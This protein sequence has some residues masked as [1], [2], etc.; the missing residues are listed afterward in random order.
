[1]NFSTADRGFKMVSHV[2]PVSGEIQQGNGNITS[3]NLTS[4]QD[5]PHS[6]KIKQEPFQLSPTSSL[7][8]LHQVSNFVSDMSS[9]CM[10]APSKDIHDVSVTNFCRS[11]LSSHHIINSHHH[12]L[13]SP[14]SA[15]SMHTLSSL[16]HPSHNNK[17]NNNSNNNNTNNTNNNNSSNNNSNHRNHH[18]HHHHHQHHSPHVEGKNSSPPIGL[19][20]STNNNNS[21]S[22]SSAPTTNSE[23]STTVSESDSIEPLSTNEKP[24]YSYVALIAMAIN[25]SSQKRA[26]LNEIYGYIT[27]NF[28]YYE[29]N[30]KGWQNSIRHNLSLNECFV[31]VPREGGGE[32]KGNFWT[33][34]PQYHD[35]FEN[36][37]FKRRKRMKR[38]YRSASYHKS[39]FG[40]SFASSHVHLNATRNLFAHSPP[41]Y[42]STGYPRYDTSTWSLQ[43]PQ[44][45]Y[46]HCQGIQSQLQPM[47]HQSMQIPTMNG[48]GQFNS[49]AFQG[50]YIDVS[51]GSSG[52]PGAMAG[53]T[54][55]SNFGA[56]K[57][58]HDGT[59]VS[60]T[61]SGRCSYWPD[62]K[63]ILFKIIL[64]YIL[65]FYI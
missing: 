62:S 3:S 47:H 63:F 60:D 59:F 7:P 20:S 36:G 56:C 48:Y 61:M 49:L 28:P 22:T 37:N 64:L 40:E 21:P 17:S 18:H 43:Q 24:P 31:K 1:M 27:T 23:A 57:R 25:R 14:Q 50:N 8:S 30:K 32:R 46:S 11:S 42:A 39:L 2:L 9:G 4:I 16:H 52:S 12:D 35:M 19:H 13:H 38:P 34:D 41:S 10:N 51:G 45:S 33:L 26:T 6:L 58:R 15:I 55:G 65:I 44:L 5:S 54:F 29:K 53:G